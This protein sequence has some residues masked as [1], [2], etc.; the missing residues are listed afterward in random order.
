MRQTTDQAPSSP[1]AV[2]RS[3]PAPTSLAK[4]EASLPVRVFA[5]TVRIWSTLWNKLL[6]RP[7]RTRGALL[8]MQNNSELHPKLESRYLV[9]TQCI[10]GK[11]H[12][13]PES[14]EI[15]KHYYFPVVNSSALKN[16][17]QMIVAH[18][19]ATALIFRSGMLL[20]ADFSRSREET[21]CTRRID[22]TLCQYE[23][24]DLQDVQSI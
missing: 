16:G 11:K 9:N 6:C 10:S 17:P 12:T 24:E 18:E 1:E 23:Q 14:G 22:G 4:T 7:E 19:L 20:Y 5:W 3:T 15:N 13:R 8:C 2:Y 21:V